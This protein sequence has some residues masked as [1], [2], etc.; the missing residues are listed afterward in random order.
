MRK[1]LKDLLEDTDRRLH[2]ERWKKA[3]EA[4]KKMIDAWNQ[5]HIRISYLDEWLKKRI[6][7]CERNWKI[8]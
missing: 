1:K 8:Q 7:E 5:E 6:E 3:E 4:T 2:P